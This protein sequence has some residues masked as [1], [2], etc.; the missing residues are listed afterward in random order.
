MSIAN[1]W[2]QVARRHMRHTQTASTDH[3]TEMYEKYA[4][5]ISMGTEWFMNREKRYLGKNSEKKLLYVIGRV[6]YTDPCSFLA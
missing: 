6:I 3:I 4:R 2:G 5:D 1:S